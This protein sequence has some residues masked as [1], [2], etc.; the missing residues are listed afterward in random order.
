MCSDR[1]I[2]IENAHEV[3]CRRS[4]C[5]ELL[6]RDKV[7]SSFHRPDHYSTVEDNDT[8]LWKRSGCTEQLCCQK[9]EWHPEQMT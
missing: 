4:R 3:K 7:W 6:Y 8:T 5:K 1:H 2:S 9:R